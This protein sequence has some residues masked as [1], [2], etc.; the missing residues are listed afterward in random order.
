MAPVYTI[1]LWE[2]KLDLI[3]LILSVRASTA[4]RLLV[5]QALFRFL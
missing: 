5:L 1:L 2:R 4:R 3:F